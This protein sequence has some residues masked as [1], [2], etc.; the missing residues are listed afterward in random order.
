MTYLSGVVI[1]WSYTIAMAL[2][3]KTA[4]LT[5]ISICSASRSRKMS[6]ISISIKVT[7]GFEKH[8][9]PNH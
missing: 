6:S 9:G 5:V 2:I 7:T 3:Q 4:A 1:I 8:I